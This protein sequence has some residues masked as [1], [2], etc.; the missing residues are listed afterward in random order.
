MIGK[1]NGSGN[2]S[3]YVLITH[4]HST[5]LET[6]NIYLETICT[7]YHPLFLTRNV[8]EAAK[9]TRIGWEISVSQMLR[10]S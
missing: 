10:Y 7:H 4:V 6:E 3:C 8:V 2:T 5:F 9:V 1:E